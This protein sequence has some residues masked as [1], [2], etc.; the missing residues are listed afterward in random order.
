MSLSLTSHK[1]D[2]NLLVLWGQGLSSM[3]TLILIWGHRNF[4]ELK[5]D[6]SDYGRLLRLRRESILNRRVVL[7]KLRMGP[8]CYV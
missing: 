8:E 4:H 7:I 6:A 1:S 5:L 3:I 2:L